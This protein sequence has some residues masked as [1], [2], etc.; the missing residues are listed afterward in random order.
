MT[1]PSGQ[2]SFSDINT[3]VGQ[4]SNHQA[5]M[6]WLK[7]LLQTDFYFGSPGTWSFTIPPYTTSI[8]INMVGGGGAGYGVH[9]GGYSTYAYPGGPGGGIANLS[10][11]VTP[12]ATCT[13]VVGQGGGGGYYNGGTGAVGN[14]S[15]SAFYIGP[16]KICVAYNGGNA[17]SNTNGSPGSG[18]IYSGTGG[19][20]VSGTSGYYRVAND[21]GYSV[22]NWIDRGTATMDAA[23]I[24]PL[25][26]SSNITPIASPVTT[27]GRA[28]YQS[29]VTTDPSRAGRSEY[30]GWVHITCNNTKSDLNS[31]HSLAY[32]TKKNQG[33]CDN[34][35]CNCAACGGACNT[36]GLCA[37]FNC[38]NCNCYT[39][40]YSPI[41]CINT[42]CSNFTTTNCDPGPA[43]Q[44]NCNCLTFNCNPNGVCY[45][46][47]CDCDCNCAC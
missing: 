17:S 12:G 28:Q 23:G 20:V 10:G 30:S 19:T 45:S 37:C 1:L 34:G 44:T 7:S 47:D 25:L 9:G 22:W 41:N 46:Y 2:I 38:G 33:Y 4:A 39:G 15:E 27:S 11:S 29:P 31:F 26:L 24:P 14:P 43:L 18:A 36:G 5:S 8:T 3:E 6:S 40:P 32:Y 35:N 42:V 21:Y 16:T 13:V